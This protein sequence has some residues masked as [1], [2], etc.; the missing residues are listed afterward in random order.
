MNKHFSIV[1][2]FNIAM[3]VTGSSFAVTTSVP[4][5]TSQSDPAIAG[6]EFAHKEGLSSNCLKQTGSHIRVKDGRVCNGQIGSVYTREDIDRTGAITTAGA[7]QSLDA[8]IQ[9]RR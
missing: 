1:A 9:I 7:L 5:S 8:A 4:M 6:A 2:V 3:L